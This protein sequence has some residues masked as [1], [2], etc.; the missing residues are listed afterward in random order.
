MDKKL[1]KKVGELSRINLTDE[2]LEKLTPQM[3]TILEAAG[4]LADIDTGSTQPMK[5]HLPFSEL[6]EDVKGES[7][8]QKDV[9][10][11]AKHTEIAHVKVYGK[12]F[13]GGEE[14]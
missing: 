10:R 2:E 9:L 1:L 4:K 6:R 3:K 14:S 12:V 7:L 5:R 8:S 11:N 13:G